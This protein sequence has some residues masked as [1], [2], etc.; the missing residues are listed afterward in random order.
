MSS[1]L[2]TVADQW[3]ESLQ[4]APEE[5]LDHCHGLYDADHLRQ[6]LSMLPPQSTVVEAGCGLGQYVYMFASL[7]HHCIGLD[8]S[9]GLLEQAQARG[10]GLTSLTGSVDW[11]EGNILEL[12]LDDASI[13]CYASFGVLEHFTRGQQQQ[14]LREAHRVI[15]PGGLLYQYVPNFW[16]PWTVRR[17]IRYWY[18]RVFPPN[19]VWQRN[20]RRAKLR[21]L[22]SQAGFSLESCQSVYA[23]VAIK[24]MAAPDRLRR[25]L[26]QRWNRGVAGWAERMGDWCDRRNTCGYG[27]VYIGRRGQ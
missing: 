13:D 18:R 24:S 20:I 27:L 6:L 14:I 12:P 8:Y 26:P 3:E 19:L 22:T 10:A 16:S 11:R 2:P 17:E 5:T 25:M 7:G 23:G 21:K 1:V 4:A 9:A 15:R